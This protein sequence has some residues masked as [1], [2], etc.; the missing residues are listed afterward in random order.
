[1]KGYSD[2]NTAAVRITKW[3][4]NS[5]MSMI[6][7]VEGNA[8]YRF[9]EASVILYLSRVHKIQEYCDSNVHLGI[10]ILIL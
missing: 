5:K 7:F 4:Q 9:D 8:R 3:M 6:I 1:M 10:K 2:N